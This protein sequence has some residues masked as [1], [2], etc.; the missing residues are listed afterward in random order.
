MATRPSQHDSSIDML[1]PSNDV[2]VSNAPA[3][4]LDADG[5]GAAQAAMEI[6]GRAAWLAWQIE[7]D[8]VLVNEAQA[9]LRGIDENIERYGSRLPADL[10]KSIGAQLDVARAAAVDADLR[11][12]AAAARNI[13]QVAERFRNSTMA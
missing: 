6:G 13:R 8:E 3:T 4:R 9:Q 11:A 5:R 12:V 1:V 2:T 10:R 7:A